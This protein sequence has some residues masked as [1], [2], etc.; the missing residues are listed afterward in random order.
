MYVN[1]HS[2]TTAVVVRSLWILSCSMIVLYKCATYPHT[3]TYTCICIICKQHSFNFNFCYSF[4][5]RVHTRESTCQNTIY[6]FYYLN[7]CV[8]MLIAVDF[9]TTNCTNK[10]THIHTFVYNTS[11]Q[12]FLA[13]VWWTVI[14]TFWIWNAFEI[15]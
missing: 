14:T 15:P 7:D 13:A 3:H 4:H 5:M 2:C 11:M 6:C 1:K 12:I 8:W 9:T 10:S